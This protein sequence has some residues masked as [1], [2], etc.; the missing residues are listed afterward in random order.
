MVRNYEVLVI[1]LCV[2]AFFLC[3]CV[4]SNFLYEN[5]LNGKAKI[6][7]IKTEKVSYALSFINLIVLLVYCVIT[8]I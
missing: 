1:M 8:K 3:V 7:F 5:V 4:V 6:F 2:L